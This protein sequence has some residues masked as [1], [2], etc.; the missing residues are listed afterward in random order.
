MGAGGASGQHE[1]RMLRL[2]KGWERRSEGWLVLSGEAILAFAS[3]VGWL[4]VLGHGSYGSG[5]G[6]GEWS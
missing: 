5:L 1:N 4:V 2:A 3:R 6:S